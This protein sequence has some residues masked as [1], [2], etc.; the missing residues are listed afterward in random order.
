M[1][2]PL[3]GIG[4]KK[5]LC[6]SS[7][8][9]ADCKAKLL[10]LPALEL[11][12]LELLFREEPLFSEAFFLSVVP[13]DGVVMASPCDMTE[14]DLCMVESSIMDTPLWAESK[15]S[16]NLPWFCC[17]MDCDSGEDMEGLPGVAKSVAADAFMGCGFGVLVVAYPLSRWFCVGWGTEL[18]L[19]DAMSGNADGSTGADVAQE[20]T[21][22]VL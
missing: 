3:V 13:L 11:R 5:A 14:S 17:V 16:V 19:R 8:S 2:F 20:S 7:V 22:S 12:R 18:E 9:V 15:S 10:T 21:S 6:I 4:E 1:G